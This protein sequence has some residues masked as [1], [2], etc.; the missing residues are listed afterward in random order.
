MSVAC[1][2]INRNGLLTRSTRT[3]VRW[4]AKKYDDN[5]D[6]DG[7]DTDKDKK[8]R[9]GGTERIEA[10]SVLGKIREN[11]TNNCSKRTYRQALMVEKLQRHE[12]KQSCFQESF[13][14]AK[15]RQSLSGCIS[16]SWWV[17]YLN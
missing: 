8:D 7:D 14:T 5:G 16:S 11:E 12:Q 17:L 3:F 13:E 2:R 6:D 10:N 4:L 1:K 15:K 9:N